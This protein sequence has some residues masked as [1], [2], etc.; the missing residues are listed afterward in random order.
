MRC[1]G[2]G[3]FRHDGG[4]FGVGRSLI[5]NARDMFRAG[6]GGRL[7]IELFQRNAQ[8]ILGVHLPDRLVVIGQGADHLAG[9]LQLLVHGAHGAPV[10]GIG[11]LLC[12][13]ADRNVERGEIAVQ[14]EVHLFRFH[15]GFGDGPLEQHR[16]PPRGIGAELGDGLQ[17]GV[18]RPGF[19]ALRAGVDIVMVDEGLIVRVRALRALQD[20]FGNK[21]RP[22]AGRNLRIAA[23][24]D[25]PD[26]L[27][28]R[29]RDA[30]L[31]GAVNGAFCLGLAGVERLHRVGIVMAKHAQRISGLAP[32]PGA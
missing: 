5:L 20:H 2:R 10:C 26:D 16:D 32:A 30:P 4:R 23:R 6:R 24:F 31:D 14:G 27:V 3:L 18:V 13:P 28:A 7:R 29:F 11:E 12:H 1:L 22:L 21:A 9:G 15:A 8:H 19:R 17:H 25:A